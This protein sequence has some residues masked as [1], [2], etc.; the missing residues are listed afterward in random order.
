[1]KI[2]IAG[3]RDFQDYEL[4][5]LSMN[6]FISSWDKDIFPKDI[7][8]VSGHASGADSLGEKFANEFG[9]KIRIFPAD[10]NFFGKSAGII[11]NRE[12]L[13]YVKIY[14]D[15]ILIAFWDGK[16]KGTKNM[17]DIAKKAGITV[18]VVNYGE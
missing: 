16:S 4:L 10:W 5:K 12:M 7:E 8:I 1:M 9:C 11:R 14:D 17:I 6:N 15:P 13:S 18:V 3:G 2:I